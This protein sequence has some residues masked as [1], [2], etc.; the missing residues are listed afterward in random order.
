MSVYLVGE[1]TFSLQKNNKKYISL[2]ESS[3]YHF[4]YL[5]I[6]VL[7]PKNLFHFKSD[8]FKESKRIS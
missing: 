1:F 6:Y 5:H 7:H 2:F 8:R 3:L 4:L